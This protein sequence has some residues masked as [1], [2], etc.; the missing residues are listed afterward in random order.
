MA[1]SVRTVAGVVLLTALGLAPLNYASTRLMPLQTLIALAATGGVAWGVS[2]LL[3]HAWALPPVAARVGIALIAISAAAWLGFL[4]LPE[5]PSFTRNHY[6]RL[7]ERWPYSV[8]PR[9]FSLLIV[10]AIA[11]ILAL[12]ALCDFARGPAWR[13]AIV[14][15][16]LCTG[17]AVSVLGL[18]QN[19]THAQGIF[20]DSSHRMPGAFFGTF[21]HHTSAGAYLNTVW[22][23]GFAIALGGIREKHRNPRVRGIIYAALACSSLIAIA[24][25]A[26]VSRLPQVIALVAFLIFA[27]WAGL[28]HALGEIRGLRVALGTIIAALLGAVIVFGATRIRDIRA[29]WDSLE[30]SGLRGGQPEVAAPPVSQWPR[31][32]RDD[33]FVPSDHHAYPLGDRGAIYAAAFRAIAARPWLGWGPGGWTA[34]A[35]AFSRDP[36]VRTFFLT[37]QFTH[38]DYLQTIVEWGLIGAAGWALLIPGALVSAVARIGFR[39]SRDYI[40]AA[41]VIALGAVLVQSLTDFPL[42]IPAVQFNAV[43]LAALAW[44]APASAA[45]VPLPSI[46]FS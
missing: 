15:V 44:S 2:C 26:H 1:D 4:P 41:A 35:A 43:A 9:N 28:W 14:A 25:S 22:P 21:F 13:L 27:I 5:W 19:A 34:A 23:L 6:A 38:S 16:M 46:P 45:T 3:A 36:F 31:L 29:R 18:L 42:E 24:H 7:V 12:V 30:W 20:W 8:M 32:M 33:L 39:P 17:A 10:W 11:A 40:G 37:V